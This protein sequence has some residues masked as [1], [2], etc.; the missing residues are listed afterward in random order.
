M[1]SRVNLAD[2]SLKKR[3]NFAIKRQVTFHQKCSNVFLGDL[4]VKQK[5]HETIR[6]SL[7]TVI[8][9]LNFFVAQ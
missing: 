6:S 7:I 3:L 5:L 8:K 2:A 1:I 9:I 4:E